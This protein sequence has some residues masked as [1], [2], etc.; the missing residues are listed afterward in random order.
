MKTINLRRRLEALEKDVSS[1]PI[2]LLMPDGHKKVVP[3]HNDYVRGL[4]GRAVHGDWTPEMELIAQ[5]QSSASGP[6]E[7]VEPGVRHIVRRLRELERR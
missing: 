3:G 5:S 6:N 1:D 4:L 7:D 2:V